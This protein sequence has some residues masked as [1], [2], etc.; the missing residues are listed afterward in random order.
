MVSQSV[1]IYRMISL[2]QSY[3]A[4]RGITVIRGKDRI[5]CNTEFRPLTLRK[6]GIIAI[7]YL[8]DNE[9][10]AKI[11]ILLQ[12]F[13]IFIDSMAVIR[14][15]CIDRFLKIFKFYGSRTGVILI[16]TQF[17]PYINAGFAVFTFTCRNG[18]L[19]LFL[20]SH[21]EIFIRRKDIQS[22]ELK[23]NIR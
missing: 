12:I 1:P 16:L 19:Q 7:D 15:G 13:K 3:A 10:G 5:I 2:Y 23:Q 11:G 14:N 6:V 8:A 20:Q 9:V 18:E 22:A 4:I 21:I 17:H